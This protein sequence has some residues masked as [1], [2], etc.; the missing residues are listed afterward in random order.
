VFA[1]GVVYRDVTERKQA[2]AALR[3]PMSGAWLARFPD[4]NPNPVIRL[5]PM[6]HSLL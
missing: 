3:E 4:E 1:V 5:R 2:E 6:E